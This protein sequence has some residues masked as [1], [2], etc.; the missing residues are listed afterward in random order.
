MPPQVNPRRKQTHPL[1]S[2][3][4]AVLSGVAV[5]NAIQSYKADAPAPPAA[6]APKAATAPA[7]AAPAPPA[8]VLTMPKGTRTPSLEPV[9]SSM[10]V[11]AEPGGAPEGVLRHYSDDSEDKTRLDEYV[12]YDRHRGDSVQQDRGRDV[13]LQRK[14]FDSRFAR[15]G[16]QG[17]SGGFDKV[18]FNSLAPARREVTVKPVKRPKP[19]VPE[20]KHSIV[21]LEKAPIADKDVFVPSLLHPED[22]PERL[23]WTEDRI[24]RVG[25]SLLIAVIGILFIMT[26]AFRAREPEE[27]R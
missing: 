14:D 4:V 26:S 25:G 18:S 6:S 8:P 13:R 9:P 24:L 17:I 15:V 10:M 2:I 22:V 1:L 5:M 11:K 23:F 16:S 12:L 7:V 3:T 19:R 27:V 21:L 20:A